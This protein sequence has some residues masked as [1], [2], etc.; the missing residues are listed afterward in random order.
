MTLRRSES[1]SPIQLHIPIAPYFPGPLIL[2]SLIICFY[3][4]SLHTLSPAYLPYPALIYMPIIKLLFTGL[5]LFLQVL[6]D[7]SGS[8]SS[9]ELHSFQNTDRQSPVTYRLSLF[10]DNCLLHPVLRIARLDS[11]LEECPVP[12]LLPWP[13]TH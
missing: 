6:P 1:C 4:N 7:L 13:S 8:A 2:Q 9:Q 11:E 12:T 5:W 10:T 3:L